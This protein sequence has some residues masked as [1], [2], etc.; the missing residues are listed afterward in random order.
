MRIPLELQTCGAQTKP[1]SPQAPSEWLPEAGDIRR[2]ARPRLRSEQVLVRKHAR[3]WIEAE[4]FRR[5][6]SN[7]KIA[8]IAP[9]SCQLTL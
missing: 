6:L 1:P 4:V 5:G 3:T 9:A 7:R 8:R 2:R